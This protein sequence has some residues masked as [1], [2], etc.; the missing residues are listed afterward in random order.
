MFQRHLDAW[1]YTYTGK[2]FALD[3]CVNILYLNE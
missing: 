1:R 2:D 3:W